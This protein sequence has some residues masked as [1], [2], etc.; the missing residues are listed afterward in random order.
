MSEERPFEGYTPEFQTS[1]LSLMYHEPSFLAMVVGVVEPEHFDE[2][3]ESHFAEIFLNYA[4]HYKDPISKEV[5]YAEIR[6]L[7]AKK[8]IEEDD[9]DKYI[10]KFAEV[11]KPPVSADW[12]K[13]EVR[14]FVC[15]K[16]MELE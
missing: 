1:V 7:K 5:V 3:E 6:N 11:V 12:I 13:K 10:R 16:G 9:L 4:K 14:D 2:K 15:S 8:K